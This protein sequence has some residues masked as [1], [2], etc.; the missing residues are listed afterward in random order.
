MRDVPVLHLQAY[1]YY[2]QWTRLPWSAPVPL[3]FCHSSS[4]EKILVNSENIYFF[5]T[6]TVHLL[7]ARDGVVVEALRYELEG[8]G[9]DS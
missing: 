1:C 9:F 7:G 5:K 2:V 6:C 3:S 4:P 8:R